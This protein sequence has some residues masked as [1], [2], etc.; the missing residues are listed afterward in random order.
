MILARDRTSLRQRIA[1]WKRDGQRIA[2]VPTM[3]NR[4]AGHLSL[5]AQARRTADRVVASIFV[6]PLQFGPDEDFERYPRSLEQDRQALQ[7]AACDLLYLPSEDELYPEG[8]DAITR[9]MVPG[10]GEELEGASRPGHF[11]GVAT[12]V[13]KLFSRVEPDIAVFGKKDYQ[14]WRL[15]EK[16][17]RDLDLPIE[18]LAGETVREDD[19][20]AMSSRNQY[21]DAEQRAAAPLLQR[22]LQAIAE[23]LRD[24]PA[25]HQALIERARQRLVQAG[26]EV[27]YLAIRERRRLLRPRPGE[28]LVVLGAAR[29]GQTRLIDNIEV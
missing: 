25:E 13:M 4:H 2:F 18:I 27:D 17:T 23:A 11:A 14:Q 6:N 1:A 28:P 29:L 9:V 22:Q 7:Q 26:F 8:D 3:G 16:M 10:L 20:L 5:I 15:I 19:G 12:V 21:L 24:G